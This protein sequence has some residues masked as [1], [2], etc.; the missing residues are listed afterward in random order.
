MKTTAEPKSRCRSAIRSRIWACTVTSR[1]VVGS[2]AIS[3]LGSL[4][5]AIAIIARCRIPPENSCGYWSTR[6]FGLGMP[7]RL[8][9]SIARSLAAR[10]LTLLCARYDSMIWSPTVKY[11]WSEDCG[12]WKII[13]APPPRKLSSC[14]SPIPTISRPPT[15]IEPE[16][17]ATL[18]SCRP[19]TAM[20]DTLLPEPDSPTMASVRPSGT[21]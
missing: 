6:R 10:L 14:F 12:S 13:A 4:T 3:S 19:S 16:M 21:E 8:S 5:R 1:A 15:L 11:G 18:R 17:R 7:T 2:S 20:L 9:I